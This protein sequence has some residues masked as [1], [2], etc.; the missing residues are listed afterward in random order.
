MNITQGTFSDRFV[1]SH[2]SGRLFK[3]YGVAYLKEL[4]TKDN[5]CS[6]LECVSAV[7]ITSRET[8]KVVTF[9]RTANTIAYTYWN[10]EHQCLIEIRL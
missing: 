1:W 2:V 4:T 9:K 8:G 10:E 6:D 3:H 7:E 5:F